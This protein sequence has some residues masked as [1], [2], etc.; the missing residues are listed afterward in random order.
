MK[1]LLTSFAL[2]LTLTCFS[3]SH[4]IGIRG[5]MNLTNASIPDATVGPDNHRA[6]FI[7]GMTYLLKF[8]DKYSFGAD[9]LYTQRG[10]ETNLVFVP[11]SYGT[12]GGGGAAGPAQG[13]INNN[14]DY[15]S[16]PVKGGIHFGNRLSGNVSAGVVPSVLLTAEIVVPRTEL[17]GRTVDVR[18]E[19]SQFDLAG[20]LEVGA[21]YSINNDF[22]VFASAGFQYSFTTFEVRN[23]F[24]EN[25]DARHYGYL[26]SI[27][28]KYAFQKDL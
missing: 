22:S 5:G 14:Y 9:L 1:L 26:I 27:G 2:A 24:T 10:Y 17:P 25:V 4:F 18:D 6:G 20:L 21:D 15:L 28:I 12:N 7:G 8:N 23:S 3:Q 11:Y 19:T 13:V 16:L